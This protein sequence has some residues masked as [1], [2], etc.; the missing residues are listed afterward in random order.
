MLKTA[1]DV[2]D[3]LGGTSKVAAF[4]ARPV[5]AVSNWRAL[6]RIPSALY[7]KFQK[8]LTKRGLRASPEVWGME[9]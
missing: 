1:N 4:A 3:A 9:E 2:I 6:G 5:Q 7:L 8:R